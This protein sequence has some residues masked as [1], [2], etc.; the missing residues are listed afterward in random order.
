MAE[1]RCVNTRDGPDEVTQLLAAARDTLACDASVLRLTVEGTE[2]V[3]G[4]GIDASV[5]SDEDLLALERYAAGDDAGDSSGAAVL[6]QLRLGSVVA[7]PCVRQDR[8]FGTLF[9]FNADPERPIPSRIVRAFAGHAGFVAARREHQGVTIANTERVNG[10]EFDDLLITAQDFTTFTAGLERILAETFGPVRVGLMVWDR[11][12]GV[13]QTLPGFFRTRRETAACY[14]IDV[15]HRESNS[16]RVF[17]SGISYASNAPADDPSLMAEWV[18]FFRP[19][20]IA[21]IPLYIG[22]EAV[23]VLHVADKSA[24]FSFE[25]ISALEQ[26]S[27]RIARSVTLM[28]ELV[29]ARRHEQLERTLNNVALQVISGDSLQVA[30]APACDQ[31]RVVTDAE[32][33]CMTPA[34]GAPIGVRPES[35]D[36]P[37]VRTAL[38]V[39]ASHP[40]M[41]SDVARPT[42]AG[43]AGWTQLHVPV[44]FGPQRIGTLSAIRVLGEPFD[45]E[46]RDALQ[47]LA[48][49]IA[50]AWA[51]DRYRRKRDELVRLRE[52]QRIAD[53]LHDDAAQLLF[54]AQVRLDGLLEMPSRSPLDAAMLTSIRSLIAEGDAALREVIGHLSHQ[55]QGDLVERLMAVVERVEAEFGLPVKVNVEDSLTGVL[56][57][58]SQPLVET[59]LRV[60][61]EALINAAKHGGPCRA[62]IEIYSD[63]S[64]RLVVRVIDDGLGPSTESSWGHGLSSLRRSVREQ[65]GELHVR[66]APAGGMSVTVTCP[67][68]A[69]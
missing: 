40:G 61:R 50:L 69:W 21:S 68:A 65:Q 39:A 44:H 16:A 60:A 64:H 25:D 57:R 62:M 13:L 67:I 58:L 56:Q 10:S 5:L 41:I 49:L 19:T 27:V 6:E 51:A 42:G 28:R 53:E 23:G 26:M 55:P 31:A 29:Q 30:L 59:L 4:S 54:A 37:E 33:V 18:T 63:D 43:D 11:S 47:R 35:A 9:A 24:P 17:A 32:V 3:R 22:P 52:R 15:S 7:V 2:L 20:R 34:S 46:E 36:L 45:P 8:R 38:A 66:R 48:Q 14:Q 12:L 1:V